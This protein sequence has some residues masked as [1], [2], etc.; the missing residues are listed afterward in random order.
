[1]S[2]R[3]MRTC[4]VLLCSSYR[5]KAVGPVKF[6]APRVPRTPREKRIKKCLLLGSGGLSIGQVHFNYLLFLVW[7]C[8]RNVRCAVREL[9]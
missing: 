5:S 4:C 1:M 8:R 9:C 2:S 7:F 6:P 3:V